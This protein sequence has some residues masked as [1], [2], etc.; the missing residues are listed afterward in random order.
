MRI[1]RILHYPGSKWRMSVICRHIQPTW[2]RISAAERCCSTK[3]LP[4]L[5]ELLLKHSGPAILSGY[6]SQ[7]YNSRLVDW[8]REEQQQVIETG[9]SR[10][11]VLWINPV[12]AGQLARCNC[13]KVPH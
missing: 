1:P 5:L 7:L 8:K 11:E 6:D 4:E 13:F 10:A 9:Q 12:T 2:S 3:S